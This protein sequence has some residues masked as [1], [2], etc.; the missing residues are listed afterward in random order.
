MCLICIEF[1]KGRMTFQEGW[2]ALGEMREQLEPGH[3]E[4]V[5]AKLEKAEAE[6]QPAAP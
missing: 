3:I 6:A 2:R 4:E 5:E 1:E